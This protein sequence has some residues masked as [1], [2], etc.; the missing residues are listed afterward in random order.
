MDFLPITTT[1]ALGYSAAALVLLTFS[2][3]SIAALRTAAIVSNVLFIA[4]ALAAAS[5]PG[6]T[7]TINGEDVSRIFDLGQWST[8]RKVVLV[9]AG[10]GL[11]IYFVVATRRT[12]SRKRIAQKYET[13]HARQRARFGRDVR[14]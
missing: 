2:L 13:R 9:L 5:D 1:D 3:R 11:G 12:A 4:Y 7:V 8:D 6:L 10:I 14:D